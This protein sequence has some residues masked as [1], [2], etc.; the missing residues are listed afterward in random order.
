ME[1]LCLAILPNATFVPAR[2]HPDECT[3]LDEAAW[4]AILSSLG[5]D[6]KGRM[7]ISVISILINV[8]RIPIQ[9]RI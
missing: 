6:Y 3:T 9:D 5:R 7:K 4:W 1:G 8:N 2:D